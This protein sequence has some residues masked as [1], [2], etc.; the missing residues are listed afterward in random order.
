MKQTFRFV[1][2]G[3]E[4]EVKAERKGEALNIERDGREYTLTLLPGGNGTESV[5][6][7]RKTTPMESAAPT[8]STSPEISGEW[9]ATESSPPGGS[10]SSPGDIPAPMTGVLKECIVSVGDRVREGEKLMIMEAMKMDIEVSSY[11][12]GTVT[13]VYVSSNDNVREGQPLIRVE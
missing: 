12:N 9:T 6:R 7:P 8:A 13:R 4:I 2:Q 1:Y 5:E 11:S 10:L 3:E